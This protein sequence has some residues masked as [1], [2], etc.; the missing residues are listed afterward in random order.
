ML[1]TPTFKKRNNQ[2]IKINSEIIK[3]KNRKFKIKNKITLAK[4]PNQIIL[5][6]EIFKIEFTDL[7]KGESGL[8][9]FDTKTIK[10]DNSLKNDLK[11]LEYVLWHELGHYFSEYYGL[12]DGEIFPT[13]FSNF[14]CNLLKQLGERKEDE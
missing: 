3:M 10:F 11:E 2:N 6:S 8:L 14:I 5:L 1:L 12:E 7:P 4:M 13:A 9:V